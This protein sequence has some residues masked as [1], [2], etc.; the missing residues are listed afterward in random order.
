MNDSRLRTYLIFV[1][2]LGW[3]FNLVA[4]TF[5]SSYSNSLAANGPLLLILGSLFAAKR[6]GERDDDGK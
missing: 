6:K 3:L 5:I 2:S 1:V 4:P